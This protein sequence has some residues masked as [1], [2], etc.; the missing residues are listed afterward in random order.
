[1]KLIFKRF[2]VT[3]YQHGLINVKCRQ[4]HKKTGKIPKKGAKNGRF[5]QNARLNGH[6]RLKTGDFSTLHSLWKSSCG[7]SSL[8]CPFPFPDFS[9]QCIGLLS[10]DII[11]ISSFIVGVRVGGGVERSQG[12]GVKGWRGGPLVL[13]SLHLI[14][15]SWLDISFSPPSRLS[16]C[17]PS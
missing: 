3:N 5:S 13:R 8:I 7:D 4:N 15:C 16:F 10:V 14:V 11:V 9:L 1:M 12:G 6:A 2:N 17:D